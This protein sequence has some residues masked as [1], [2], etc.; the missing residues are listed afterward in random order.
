MCVATLYN[1]IQILSRPCV[2]FYVYTEFWIL[3]TLFPTAYWLYNVCYN[4]YSNMY[5]SIVSSM[6]VAAGLNKKQMSTQITLSIQ[7]FTTHVDTYLITVSYYSYLEPAAAHAQYCLAGWHMHSLV[8][9]L[10]FIP[11]TTVVHTTQ[12]RGCRNSEHAFIH[13]YLSYPLSA[14]PQ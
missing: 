7:F 6:C 3:A 14:I 12:L 11:Q 2:S 8:G 9:W 5:N 1:Y 10:V 4:K 13:C